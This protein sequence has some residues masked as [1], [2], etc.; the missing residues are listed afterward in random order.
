MKRKENEN[1]KWN[2]WFKKLKKEFLNL[3][4]SQIQE[5]K[6]RKIKNE[7]RFLRFSKMQMGENFFSK[8]KSKKRYSKEDKCVNAL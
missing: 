1:A 2:R 6:M 3:E 4:L 7:E 5:K 8:T